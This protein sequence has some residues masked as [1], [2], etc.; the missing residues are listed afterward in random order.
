MGAFIRS[1]FLRDNI[2][3]A[4]AVMCVVIYKGAG[5]GLRYCGGRVVAV[6]FQ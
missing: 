4:A 1:L 5:A 3:A 2:S 6:S